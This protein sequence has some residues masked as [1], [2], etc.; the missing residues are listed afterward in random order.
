[1]PSGRVDD[2]L[3]TA[4]TAKLLDGREKKWVAKSG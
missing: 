1:M 2:T 4:K 3:I